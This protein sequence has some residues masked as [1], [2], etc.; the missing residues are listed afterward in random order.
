M[1][2]SS[3]LAKQ[4]GKPGRDSVKVGKLLG[5]ASTKPWAQGTSPEALGA[6][7]HAFLHRCA[8]RATVCGSM[9]AGVGRQAV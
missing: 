2:W 8:C 9:N 7:L 6:S 4:F 5:K 3:L 1:D